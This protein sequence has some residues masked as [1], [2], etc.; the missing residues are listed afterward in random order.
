MDS[1]L[2]LCTGSLSSFPALR[3]VL[4]LSSEAHTLAVSEGGLSFPGQLNNL[5]ISMY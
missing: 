4:V 2:P 5:G 3:M 1:V